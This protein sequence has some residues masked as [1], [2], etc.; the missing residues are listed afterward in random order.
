MYT[1]CTLKSVRRVVVSCDGL[2]MIEVDYK[3]TMRKRRRATGKTVKEILK[4]EMKEMKEKKR[5][6]KKREEKRSLI[7]YDAASEGMR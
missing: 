7:S 5:K 6:E 1:G 3:L 2:S 4:S